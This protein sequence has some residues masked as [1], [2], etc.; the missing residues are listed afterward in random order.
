MADTQ[1]ILVM[2]GP[3]WLAISILGLGMLIVGRQ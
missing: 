2:F 1:T 3:L